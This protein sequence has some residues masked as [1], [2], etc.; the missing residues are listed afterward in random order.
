MGKAPTW[1]DAVAVLDQP[2]PSRS[3]LAPSRALDA[4]EEVL[5]VALHVEADQVAGQ[6]AP[7]QLAIPRQ[8]PEDVVGRKRNVQEEGL[9]EHR[10]ASSRRMPAGREHQLVVVDPDQVELTGAFGL[11]R[12]P[13]RFRRSVGSRRSYCGE[14]AAASKARL[15]PACECSRGHSVR[16]REAVVVADHLV[17]GQSTTASISVAARSPLENR[18]VRAHAPGRA[19]RSRCRRA[20][21]AR[22]PG[23]TPDHPG[24]RLS[25]QAVADP[26]LQGVGQPVAGD[27]DGL[28]AAHGGDGKPIR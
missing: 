23:R 26:R 28:V 10:R 22:A 20:C 14:V 8:Q 2:W 15:G 21:A 27:D 24:E 4:V 6:E 16:F 18:F 1:V 11:L 12:R 9:G 25:L 7:Q 5:G 19:S 17:L 3:T 13:P